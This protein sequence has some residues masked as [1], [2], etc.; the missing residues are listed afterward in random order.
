VYAATHRNG[1]L[2]AIKVLHPELCH[3]AALKRRF[4]REG[5]LANKV[6][7]PGAVRV[8]DDDATDDGIVYLVME[9][10]EGETLKQRWDKEDRRLDPQLVYRVVDEVL[11]VLESA[12][13]HAVVHRDLKPDNIFLLSD[14]TTKILDF[15]IAR[16]LEAS[17]AG[18]GDATASTAMMGTPAYM[19]PEQALAQWKK[20]D[21]RTDLFALGATAFTM[22]SGQLVH[23]G[24]TVQELL[25]S[26]ST[27]PPCSLR[28]VMPHLDSGIATV[29]D[30]ALAFEMDERWQDAAAMRGALKRARA[31]AQS[32]TVK[33]LASTPLQV[34]PGTE[35]A[36][37]LDL[38]DAGTQLSATVASAESSPASTATTI[39][40][41]L[42]AD[43]VASVRSTRKVWWAAA[44]IGL[45]AAT[46]LV[47]GAL[48]LR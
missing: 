21:G 15:G 26:A 34:P 6:G 36:T 44:V 4:L 23:Q 13:A 30:R 3:N 12:H 33:L 27:R 16:M 40:Q 18:S 5:Y 46:V 42:L 22:L 47:I 1:T 9:L 28:T 19:P 10:L 45:V 35:S 39:V 7:H 32:R 8:L 43:R 37:I 25:V 2:G 31:S 41:P 20:V 48:L 38:P 14:G 29:I 24:S 11:D 17:D